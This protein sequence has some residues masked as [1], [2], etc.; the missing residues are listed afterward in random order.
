MKLSIKDNNLV[1]LCWLLEITLTAIV[2]MHT[3]DIPKR[4]A[5][6]YTEIQNQLRPSLE[7]I[8][9][10]NDSFEDQ[11]RKVL[12]VKFAN[13][14]ADTMNA[15]ITMLETRSSHAMHTVMREAGISD[16]VIVETLGDRL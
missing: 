10:I 12:G 8:I 2:K 9:E 3:E 13:Q 5:E 7:K 11:I 15:V 14:L 6:G 1:S 4:K 16:R